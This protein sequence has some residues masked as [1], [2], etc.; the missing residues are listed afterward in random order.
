MPTLS[1]TI[2]ELSDAFRE[3]SEIELGYLVRKKMREVAGGDDA[4]ERMIADT[5]K[6]VKTLLT[7]PEMRPEWARKAVIDVELPKKGAVTTCQ[8]L[9]EVV[10]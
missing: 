8:W 3:K 4:I 9:N 6:Q 2:Q 7:S 5:V 1:F 10:V